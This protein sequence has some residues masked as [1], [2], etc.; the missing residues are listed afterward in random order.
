MPPD[1]RQD[2]KKRW[3]EYQ[4]LPPAERHKIAPP[5]SETRAAARKRPSE[6]RK[7]AAAS[8]AYLEW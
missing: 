1:K 8:E 4:A 6:P 5:K 7:P 3:A 2:L